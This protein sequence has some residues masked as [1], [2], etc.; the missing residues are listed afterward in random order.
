MELKIRDEKRMLDAI[1]ECRELIDAETMAKYDSE[2]AGSLDECDYCGETITPELEFF[3]DAEIHL[4]EGVWGILC[5]FC[6][7]SGGNEMVWGRGQLYHYEPGRKR[8][9]LV[10]GFPPENLR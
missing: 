8:W 2:W 6:L 9:R 4:D 7:I 10:A 3:A 5:P 1:Q